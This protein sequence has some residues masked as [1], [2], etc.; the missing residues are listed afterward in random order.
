METVY[1]RNQFNSLLIWNKTYQWDILQHVK[2]INQFISISW[3]S[4]NILQASFNVFTTC[5]RLI[6]KMFHPSI[7]CNF[8]TPSVKRTIGK[9]KFNAGILIH[10]HRLP[11][12]H[13]K[14]EMLSFHITFGFGLANITPFRHNCPLVTLMLITGSCD[15]N[16]SQNRNNGPNVTALPVK[17]RSH[18]ELAVSFLFL[19]VPWCLLQQ[20]AV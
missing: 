13:W 9:N 20:P 17:R 7:P 3:Q 11:W 1:F 15:T 19:P 16:A 12:G 8:S 18:G 4:I 5:S 6:L 2:K 10:D 14:S